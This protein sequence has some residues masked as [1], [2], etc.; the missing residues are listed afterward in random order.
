[1]VI[2]RPNEQVINDL[3]TQR[4]CLLGI[5]IIDY[6]LMAKVVSNGISEED[7]EELGNWRAFSLI[8]AN[9]LNRVCKLSIVE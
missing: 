7:K 3:L 4:E 9:P 8:L 1:M 2:Y 5:R 6:I